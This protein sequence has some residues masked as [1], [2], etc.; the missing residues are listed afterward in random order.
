[1]KATNVLTE[2]PKTAKVTLKTFAG[3]HWYL[4]MAGCVLSGISSVLSLVPYYYMWLVIKEVII[5][6]DGLAAGMAGGGLISPKLSGQLVSYGWKAVGISLL[7]MA[8][9]Y[10]ALMCTHLSAFRTATNLKTVA[11]HQLTR[12]P[13][14]YFKQTGSGKL[15][16]IIDDGAGQTETYLAHQL[17]DLAGAFVTPVAVLGILLLFDWRFGLISLLPVV[18]GVIFLFQMMGPGMEV[19]MAK[20]QDALEDMNSEAVEYVRG[21][22]VVKTFQ[23]SVFSFKNFH[24][25]ILRYRD[26]SVNYTLSMRLPM[27]CYTVSINAVF[28]FL[29]PA[30]MLLAGDLITGQSYMTC[31]LDLVFYV[32]FTPVCVSM[33]DKIMH[34]SENTVEA[35]DAVKRILNILAVRPLAEPAISKVPA[36]MSV[37]F[38]NV[39]FSYGE[40]YGNAL[41]GVSFQIPAGSLTAVVGPSGG[42]KTTAASL[43]PRFFDVSSGSI[44][45]GG[46]DVRE[47][48]SEELMKYVA[49]VFQDSH[50][51]KKSILDNIRAAKPEADQEEV[52][53]AVK[54]ARCE[55]IIAKMPDGLNTVI[56]TKGVYLSGGE[57]QRIALCRAILKDAPIVILDEASAF[58]DPDNEYEI[59]KAFEELA[60]GKTVLMIAHRLSTVCR[61]DQILVLSDGQ[62][63]EAGTHHELLQ[64]EGLYASMWKEYQTSAAWKVGGT[65]E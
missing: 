61:A 25:S 20:Y 37:T 15:R 54:A 55:D 11:M 27:C 24:D 10:L 9:Y 46:V 32:L 29:I 17:P 60:R 44:R 49:F 63:K 14:G 64:R 38:D 56:G 18:I 8:V 35:K 31:V 4:T 26:W 13:I 40:N 52:W 43:I 34:V 41:D 28:A 57:C 12:L 65:D 6:W 30:G 48:K 58:A 47:M 23:Q 51:F 1:M 62:L 3:K 21:I 16:R 53:R 59:Q 7:S 50:L 39:V 45:I 5:N 22:P 2:I 42:G 33:M 36:D 19:M